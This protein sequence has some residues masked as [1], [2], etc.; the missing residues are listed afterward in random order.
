MRLLIAI[1]VVT[2]LVSFA[3]PKKNFKPGWR[4]ITAAGFSAGQSG[5]GAVFQLSGGISTPSFFAGIG[6]GYDGYEFRSWP[7][8]ADLRLALG[9]RRLVFVYAMPGY[10]IS[11]KFSK[12]LSTSWRT[13]DEHL[14]GGFY[15]D[16]G[17]GYRVP[18]AFR[19]RF[20]FSAGYTRKSVVHQ[21]TYSFRCNGEPCPGTSPESFLFRY[22]YGLLTAKISWEFGK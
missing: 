18:L 4:T 5:A 3:Q 10:N 16:A 7:V 1:L 9:N 6:A 22:R 11:G 14:E 20:A 15:I 19:H 2:P 8:F 13:V 17:L 12:E 21:K